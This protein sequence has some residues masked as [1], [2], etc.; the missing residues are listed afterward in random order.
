M[1]PTIEEEIT[2]LSDDFDLLL[3]VV[4]QPG[5]SKSKKM[6]SLLRVSTTG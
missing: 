6:R 4:G 2:F 1:E 5:L 3:Q